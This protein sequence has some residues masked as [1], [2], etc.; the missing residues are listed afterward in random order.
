MEADG[1]RIL[2]EFF[3]LTIVASFI[4]TRLNFNEIMT[5]SEI[6]KPNSIVY[7]SGF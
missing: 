2:D 3:E 6:I 5:D 4:N 7:Y 1:S